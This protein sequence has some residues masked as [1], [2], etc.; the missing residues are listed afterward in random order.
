MAC[1]R[2]YESWSVIGSVNCQAF[3]PAVTTYDIEPYGQNPIRRSF[4]YNSCKTALVNLFTFA[5]QITSETIT[6]SFNCVVWLT[7]I[8]RCRQSKKL[9]LKASW[10]KIY[11]YSVGTWFLA[12][13][14]TKHHYWSSKC[15]LCA[16]LYYMCHNADW[17]PWR[18]SPV[19]GR[20]YYRA[21]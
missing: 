21:L 3:H 14:L 13:R 9:T 16:C 11:R 5:I 18:V 1:L 2:L 4:K 8:F 19:V 6:L 20:V 7:N 12:L 10:R 17:R 15:A